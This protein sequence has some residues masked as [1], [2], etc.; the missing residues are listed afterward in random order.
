MDSV[1]VPLSA[2]QGQDQA[3]MPG[4]VLIASKTRRASS[5]RKRS[6]LPSHTVFSLP[7]NQNRTGVFLSNTDGQGSTFLS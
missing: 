5:S 6:E 1:K 2:F 3:A 7:C 4:T